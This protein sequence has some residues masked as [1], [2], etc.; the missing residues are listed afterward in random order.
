MTLFNPE[1]YIVLCLFAQSCLTLCDPMNCSPPGSSAHGISQA[2]ILEWV[3]IS[4]GSNP[5]LL[6]LLHWKADSLPLV[7]PGKPFHSSANSCYYNSVR[8]G[9]NYFCVV[10]KGNQGSQSVYYLTKGHI[11]SSSCWASLGF[12]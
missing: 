6:H 5:D 8:R 9:H 7:P 1:Y 4:Q 2:R 3:A 10:N 12:S 11:P